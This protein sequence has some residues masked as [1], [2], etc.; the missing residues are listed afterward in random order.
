MDWIKLLTTFVDIFGLPIAVAGIWLS[1]RNAARSHDVQVILSFVD[2]FRTKWEGGWSDLLLRL[3]PVALDAANANDIKQLRYML[4]WIDWVGR[5][6]QTNVLKNEDVI[7]SSLKPSLQ[8]AIRLGEP[9][10]EKDNA[11]NGTDFW[12]GVTFVSKRLERI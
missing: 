9:I 10:M 1:M 2:S 6:A 7:L 3:E 12:S 5:L 11:A 8:R 4:N